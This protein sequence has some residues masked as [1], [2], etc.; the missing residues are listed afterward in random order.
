MWS[1]QWE[2]LSSS[3]EPGRGTSR[4]LVERVMLNLEPSSSATLGATEPMMRWLWVNQ[5]S[6]SWICGSGEALWVTRRPTDDLRGKRR[7]Q[8]EWTL[9]K[10]CPQKR[11][12]IV[13]YRK[14]F[15]PE[16][17]GMPLGTVFG[18]K[19]K[20]STPNGSRGYRLI[21]YLPPETFICTFNICWGV[22]KGLIS[23]ALWHSVKST[24]CTLLWAFYEGP[25]T[26]YLEAHFWH[27]R[28]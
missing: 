18:P 6:F 19:K 15:A 22:E 3:G 13:L 2:W 24:P 14:R 28:E 1:V 4:R 27:L 8:G 12:P 9:F 25:H 21:S 5:G 20:F 23:L 17:L 16:N 26:G 11:N 7:L 10:T